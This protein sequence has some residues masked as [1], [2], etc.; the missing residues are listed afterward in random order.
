MRDRNT[1]GRTPTSPAESCRSRSPGGH[2]GQFSTA[3]RPPGVLL[4]RPGVGRRIGDRCRN[5]IS[6]V[7][8][9]FLARLEQQRI[10]ELG[11]RRRGGWRTVN[12]P[13]SRAT[14]PASLLPLWSLAP[15]RRLREKRRSTDTADA[16]V[17]ADRRFHNPPT[18]RGDA[19]F[20]D[21]KFRGLLPTAAIKRRL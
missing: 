15:P 11:G 10:P 4:Q 8:S 5:R 9:C 19:S 3:A 2:R 13:T 17:Y 7:V 21:A 6:D 1:V 18:A 16:E 20:A 12:L 14:L